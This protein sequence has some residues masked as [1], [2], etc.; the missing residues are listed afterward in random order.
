M[1]RHVRLAYVFAYA[2]SAE[3]AAAACRWADEAKPGS[4]DRL[5]SFPVT[6]KDLERLDCDMKD[7]MTPIKIFS[8][9]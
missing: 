5:R 2:A 4:L 3:W 8:S 1:Q 9:G 6:G 7:P